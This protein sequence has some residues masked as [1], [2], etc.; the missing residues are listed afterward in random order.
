MYRVSKCK[1]GVYAVKINDIY[2][3]LDNIKELIAN[4]G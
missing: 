4:N 2:D 3:D 1:S